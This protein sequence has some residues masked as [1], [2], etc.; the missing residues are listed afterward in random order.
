MNQRKCNPNPKTAP[1]A[2]RSLA[3][4]GAARRGDSGAA[5]R[6]GCRV[7]SEPLDPRHSG[8]RTPVTNGKERYD[9]MGTLV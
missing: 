1:P 7:E 3:R 2:A 5:R 8:A 6:G 9:H 4:R